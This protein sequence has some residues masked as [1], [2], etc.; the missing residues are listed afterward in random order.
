MTTFLKL[1]QLV[2]AYR[3]KDTSGTTDAVRDTI[4]NSCRRE[5][6]N[7]YP[8]RW[9]KAT[10]TLTL[11]SKESDIDDNFNAAF[12]ISYA[13]DENS[14]VYTQISPEEALSYT[15]DDDYVFYTSY[16]TDTGLYKLTTPSTCTTL[17]ITYYVLPDDLSE[18]TDVDLCPD[19]EAI[20]L[21]AVAKLWMSKERD[22]TNHDRYLALSNA[23][24]LDLIAN[25][26]K[27]AEKKRA[28]SLGERYDT[29][30]S[31]TKN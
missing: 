22:E 30:Y 24:I 28:K 25:D 23:R 12:G 26:K 5:I 10:E 20:A 8:F 3:G 18:D 21:G 29:G 16:N 31:L 7:R 6:Y 1:K 4:I 9:A 19:P 13:Y 2:E 15:A 14:N 27:W 11:S 17:Y